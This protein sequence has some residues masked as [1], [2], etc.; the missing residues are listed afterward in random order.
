MVKESI[1]TTIDGKSVDKFVA[2]VRAATKSGKKQ[3]LKVR[4]EVLRL[5]S[6]FLGQKGSFKEPSG[7]TK[8][9][10]SLPS[11]APDIQG[12]DKAFENF[13]GVSI[14]PT[15]IQG[16]NTPYAFLEL[17]QKVS[18][19]T[20]TTITSKTLPKEL[21]KSFESTMG[22][23]PGKN[24][25]GIISYKGTSISSIPSDTIKTF[26]SKDPKLSSTITAAAKEKFE[27]YL[28]INYLDKRH[29]N[30]P[31]ATLVPD[32]ANLLKLNSLQSPYIKIEARQT[33]NVAKTTLGISFQI[34][35]SKAGERLLEKHAIDVTAKFHKSLGKRVSASFISYAKK[36]ISSGNVK[37]TAGYMRD[38]ITLANEFADSSHTPIDIV[39]EIP[40]ASSG[41]LSIKATYN[42]AKVKQPSKQK[43]I[44]AIQL[45]ALT[46]QRLGA[47]MRKVGAA[48]PPNFTERSGRF[49][50]SVYVSPD[51]RRNLIY[52]SYNPL[53]ESNKQYGYNPDEQIKGAVRYVAQQAFAR[54]FNLI[55]A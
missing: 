52:Y 25:K 18:S 39:T 22:I 24:D 16:A 12:S 43:F 48:S 27:N 47:T 28:L 38:V 8:N 46:Q 41:A 33:R 55:K 6:D 5:F 17:K 26:I 51:Y 11:A 36:R 14:A 21:L 3:N 30:K 31:S 7:R 53:Y 23:S 54:Q 40:K 49:R 32:A 29:N 42:V 13:F 34:N 9:L 10:F 35:L 1:V 4:N 45:T 20:D 37:D 44:S 50:S 15:N 19:S 2:E